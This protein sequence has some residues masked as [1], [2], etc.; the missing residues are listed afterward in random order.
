MKHGNK[1][2]APEVRCILNEELKGKLV[3]FHGIQMSMGKNPRF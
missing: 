2:Q 3:R 1:R